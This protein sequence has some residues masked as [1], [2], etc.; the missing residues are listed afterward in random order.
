[1]AGKH[2]A[3]DRRKLQVLLR[4]VREEA[5]LTQVQVAAKLGVPQSFVS[6]YESGERK[7]ELP[8]IDAICR[9]VGISLADF[10]RRYE[11]A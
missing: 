7:L 9:A 10:V 8:E 6:K 11:R 5:S 2:L 3:R 1:M 4:T